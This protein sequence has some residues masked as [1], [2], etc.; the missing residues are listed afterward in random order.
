[1]HVDEYPELEQF[2][3]DEEG[4]AIAASVSCLE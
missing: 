4:T 2:V 3:N 1:M